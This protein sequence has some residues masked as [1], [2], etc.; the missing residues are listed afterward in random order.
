M[1]RN[2][3]IY[4][5]FFVVFR[6]DLKKKIGLATALDLVIPRGNPA[7]NMNDTN[8][9][10]L[11]N[12]KCR[13]DV[14]NFLGLVHTKKVTPAYRTQTLTLTYCIT[15]TLCDCVQTVYLTKEKCC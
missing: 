10:I 5:Y 6:S 7:N 11:F 8:I 3:V 4:I 1:H 12:T 9:G 14:C 2:N 15:T 13:S